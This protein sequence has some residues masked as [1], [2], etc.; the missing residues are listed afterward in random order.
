MYTD[1]V[2][3][4]LTALTKCSEMQDPHHEFGNLGSRPIVSFFGITATPE[5][6]ILQSVRSINWL[7][8]ANFS[9]ESDSTVVY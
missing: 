8:G 9:R 4:M 1:T 7:I 3:S 2:N 6:F 5:A